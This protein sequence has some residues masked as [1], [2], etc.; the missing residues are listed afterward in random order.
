METDNDVPGINK[1]F[2]DFNILRLRLCR[3]MWRAVN[4]YGCFGV[5][6]IEVW[7]SRARRYQI[8]TI[9]RQ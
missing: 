1:S 2:G 7:A 5:G 8:L 4:E 6:V 9:R 3:V